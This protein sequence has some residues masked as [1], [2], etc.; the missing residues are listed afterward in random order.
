MLRTEESQ[1][2]LAVLYSVLFST[3]QKK[4]EA[5]SNCNSFNQAILVKRPV[6]SIHLGRQPHFGLHLEDILMLIK[7]AFFT[8]LLK[9]ES[10]L[11][12]K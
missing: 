3:K 7:P 9:F 10:P 12:K 6:L 5:T 2:L 4:L 1:D 8:R 11:A